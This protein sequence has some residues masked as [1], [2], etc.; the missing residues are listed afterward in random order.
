[1]SSAAFCAFLGTQ[2]PAMPLRY[3]SRGRPTGRCRPMPANR[4]RNRPWILE[5]I[6]WLLAICQ[7]AVRHVSSKRNGLSRLTANGRFWVSAATD[8]RCPRGSRTDHRIQGSCS[9]SICGHVLAGTA[10]HL[11]P[12]KSTKRS[13]WAG[14]EPA[15]QNIARK[16]G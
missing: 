6:S 2:R 8:C 7:S 11:K 12:A 4:C 5:N 9:I 14:N 16:G 13:E 1:M 15:V 3:Y 10:A